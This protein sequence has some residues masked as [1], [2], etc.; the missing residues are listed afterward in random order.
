MNCNI[1]CAREQ[2]QLALELGLP[3]KDEVKNGLVYTFNGK[4]YVAPSVSEMLDW[5]KDRLE[6]ISF[7]LRFY[8]TTNTYGYILS[9]RGKTVER[10]EQCVTTFNSF[11]EAV[12]DAISEALYHLKD[13]MKP[14]YLRI[15]EEQAN[16]YAEKYDDCILKE[17][18]S[19]AYCIGA[20]TQRLI[21]IGMACEEFERF[22]N[23]RVD[24]PN[25]QLSKSDF[26]AWVAD[27]RSMLK[28]KND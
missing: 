10:N 9:M 3:I 24:N 21:D 12:L 8:P 14:M 5:L 22:L 26:K 20:Q 6:I 18:A 11:E 4:L 15:I 28:Q 1:L 25:Y 16:D 7:N 13:S 19:E 17:T 2:V 23:T 27:F